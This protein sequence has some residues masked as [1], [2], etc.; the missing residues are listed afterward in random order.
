MKK[1]AIVIGTRPEAIKLIP[2]YLKL[3]ESNSF[4]VVIISTGQH[5]EMLD[6][7]FLFFEIRPQVELNLMTQNQTLSDITALLFGHLE[8]SFKQI[9]PQLVIVQGDTTTAMVAAMVGFYNSIKVAHVEA[10]LRSFNKQSPFPE[11]VNR[12]VISQ[13][14]DLHFVPT[15]QAFINLSNEFVKNVYKVGNTVI[16]SL[17]LA[18]QTIEANLGSYTKKFSALIDFNKKLVLVTVHRRESFGEGLLNILKAIHRLAAQYQEV[19]FLFPTHLNP[20]VSKPVENILRALPNV[21][22]L[23]PLPYDDMIFI[24]SK[25]Y[26]ILTDSGGIQEE[27][28]S[29]NVPLIVLRDLTE[30][31]EGVEIGCAVIGGTDTNQ[32]IDSFN[33]IFTNSDRYLRMAST[34]NPYGDGTASQQITDIIGKTV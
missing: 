16:D 19:E 5:R 18:K 30:R 21:K 26:I 23:S 29:F 14:A 20:N 3:R 13:V 27:A 6:Q 28:P 24:M 33:Y 15:D 9:E 31:P 12:R 32:I 25:A 2:V 1:I 8:K 22:L 34:I 7:I 17:L 11:E 4:E 10:G